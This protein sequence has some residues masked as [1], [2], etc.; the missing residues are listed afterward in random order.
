MPR[1]NWDAMSK[2]EIVSGPRASCLY[3]Q[4]QLTVTQCPAASCLASRARL[5]PQANPTCVHPSTPPEPNT[6]CHR[7]STSSRCWP[8]WTRCWPSPVRGP[9]PVL[10][11]CCCLIW[12]RAWSGWSAHS[13]MHCSVL[14][15]ASTGEQHCYH[16]PPPCN[17]PCPS[18]PLA[19]H[20][21]SSLQQPRPWRFCRCSA[22]PPPCPTGPRTRRTWTWASACPASS[23]E[24]MR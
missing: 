12:G 23:G 20:P 17:V 18:C 8:S 5:Y 10:V 14:P 15:K 3:L 1:I 16:C 19:P 9:L 21:P 2:E 4:A 6:R 7:T 22:R 11:T 24:H 13:G